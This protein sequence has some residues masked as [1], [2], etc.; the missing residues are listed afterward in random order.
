MNFAR[1]TARGQTTIPKAIRKA[2][3]LQEG[4]VLAFEVAGDH[5]VVRKLTARGDEYRRSVE[6]SLGEWSMAEDEKAFGD[7]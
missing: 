7:L 4:D 5:V 1:I 6:N 2:A 3:R